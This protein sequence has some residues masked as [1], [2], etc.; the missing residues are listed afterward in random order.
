MQL[1]RFVVLDIDYILRGREDFK[2]KLFIREHI[3]LIIVQFAQF[4]LVV[5]VFWLEGFRDGKL[6]IYSGFLG[7][8]LLLAYLTYQYLSRR[9]FYKRLSKPLEAM[10]EALVRENHTPIYNALHQL[11]KSYYTL[12]Q[13][14]LL[15]RS[16]KQEEQLIFIDLW[17]HQMKTP[18]SV[19]EL[20]ARDLDEPY[21]SSIRDENEKLQNGLNTVL[22]MSRFRLIEQ[23]FQVKRINLS[24][25]VQQVNQENKRL[26]IRNRVY[27]KVEISDE[28]TVESDEKW[29]FFMISQL[30][31]NAVK[32]STER[33][34]QLDIR[35]YKERDRT[36][37]EIVD[38]GVGIPKEDLKRIFNAFYTG[39]NGRLFKESTG[40]GLYVTKEVADYLGHE[41][42]VESKVGEGTT[43]RIIF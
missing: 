19:I 5:F 40:V 30:V 8:M 22:Y 37:L 1:K 33:S 14:E 41:L 28:L 27:P 25:I 10:D 18:I 39:A 16:D 17:V 12:Y 26:F 34:N 23:D 13:N 4:C 43:F 29:L 11:L 3:L 35:G 24:H 31:H 2:M 36:L 15:K 21:S 9:T 32:Y 6:A 20:M 7:M 42:E 38:Y